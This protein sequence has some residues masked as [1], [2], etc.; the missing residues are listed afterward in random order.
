MSMARQKTQLGDRPKVEAV[1]RFG[2]AMACFSE[3]IRNKRS[4]QN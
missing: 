2:V 4:T 1:T 3:E